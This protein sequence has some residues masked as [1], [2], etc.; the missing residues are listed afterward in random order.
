[1]LTVGKVHVCTGVNVLT[2]GKL[3]TGVCVCMCAYCGQGMCWSECSYCG[4]GM[5]WSVM[6]VCVLTGY[7]LSSGDLNNKLLF[8]ARQCGTFVVRKQ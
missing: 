4:Q 5:Y 1:M 6:F 2:V 3:C 7:F 8:Q